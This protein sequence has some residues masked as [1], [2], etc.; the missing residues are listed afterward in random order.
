MNPIF[1][2]SL[3]A[4]FHKV[5]CS[6]CDR[7]QFVTS[8]FMKKEIRCKFCGNIIQIPKNSPKVK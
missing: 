1:M 4:F 7:Y 2:S 6:K 3:A 5:K 8:K